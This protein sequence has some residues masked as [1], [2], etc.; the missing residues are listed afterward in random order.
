MKPLLV[1]L[2]IL[3]SQRDYAQ[4]VGL[5][6]N[7]PN[8][9]A[10]L[11]IKSPNK[12][13]LIPRMD[14]VI[15]KQIA[16]TKGLLVYDITTNS[17][18][19]NDGAKWVNYLDMIRG[20]VT[21]DMLY[22]N[23]SNWVVIPKGLPGQLL[24]A[25]ASGLPEWQYPAT[26]AINDVSVTEG[27]T[28][29]LNFTFTVT[30][31][32][33]DDRAISVQYATAN[34]TAAAGT[35][36]TPVNGT[37]N[38]LPAEMSKT[39]TV[40][41]N[42]DEQDAEPDE[43]FSLNLFNAVSA[44]ITDATGTG[45]IINDDVF[46][47]IYFDLNE[48]TGSESSEYPAGYVVVPIFLEA[49]C[50]QPVTVYFECKPGTAILDDDYFPAN[51]F[52]TFEAGQTEAQIVFAITADNIYEGEETFTVDL[53]SANGYFV[54]GHFTCEIIDD[55]APPYIEIEDAGGFES[56]EGDY[57]MIFK[58]H[59]SGSSALP[60][61]VKYALSN[62]TAIMDAPEGNDFYPDF[63]N[64]IEFPG[65]TIT[66]PPMFEGYFQILVHVI[67]DFESEQEEYFYINLD[68]P[69]NGIILTDKATGTI[70]DDDY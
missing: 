7:S 10:I 1:L 67:N 9:N 55:D 6:T 47:E 45:I 16:S 15:R 30:K 43:T 34:G 3:A 28:G 54:N 46:P 20:N 11:E 5:G 19:H 58:V 22:W 37:L 31:T 41:V 64:T 38:F 33:L 69:V 23:G 35:D 18:W 40:V 59:I 29:T 14:S 21:Q 44:T 63:G 50:N 49:P 56:I 17:L 48:Y 66:F 42:S 27:N 2:F 53:T 60:V 8:A 68:S 36:Y 26:L 25:N 62:G 65:N 70:F 52:V 32:S 39:I 12:G 4:N 61:K 51:G 57:L 24:V 13:I